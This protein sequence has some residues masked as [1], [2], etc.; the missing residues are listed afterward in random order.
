MESAFNAQ[1]NQ[2]V[3]NPYGNIGDVTSDV[4]MDMVGKSW[5]DTH[6]TLSPDFMETIDVSQPVDDII[7]KAGSSSDYVS[8]SSDSEMKVEKEVYGKLRYKGKGRERK[9]YFSRENMF[10]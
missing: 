10:L 5:L 9:R 3:P 4:S 8:I 6:L 2:I 7:G 1:P